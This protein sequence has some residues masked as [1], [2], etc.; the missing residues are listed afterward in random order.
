MVNYN[1]IIEI[2]YALK[3]KGST[4]RCFHTSI[5]INKS[6][7]LS[8]GINNYNKTH[9]KLKEFGYNP[10]SKLHSEMAACLRLGLTDCSNLTIVNIRINRNNKLDNSKFCNGCQ[11]LIRQLNFSKAFYTN[12]LGNFEKFSLDN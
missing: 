12:K 7:I 11:N 9:P 8:I 5:I 4:G 2:C 6:K 10:L 3:D 1:R